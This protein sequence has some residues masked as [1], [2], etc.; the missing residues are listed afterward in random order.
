MAYSEEKL[1]NS[2]KNTGNN[3]V[4]Q[5]N[6]TGNTSDKMFAYQDYYRLKF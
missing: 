5:T 1:K 4:F 3:A 2:G 6:L